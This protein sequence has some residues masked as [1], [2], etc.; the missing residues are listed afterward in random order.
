M[1][2]VTWKSDQGVVLEA[3]SSVVTGT[4]LQSRLSSGGFATRSFLNPTRERG[5]Q[6]GASL[7]HRVTKTEQRGTARQKKPPR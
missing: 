4:G 2:E 3:A 7:T 5:I 6:L 1:N